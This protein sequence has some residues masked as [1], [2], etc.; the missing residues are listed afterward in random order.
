MPTEAFK[1]IGQVKFVLLGAAIVMLTIYCFMMTYCTHFFGIWSGTGTYPAGVLLLQ[2]VIPYK[3]YFCPIPFLTIIK[4]AL[5]IQIFGD[6]YIVMR[7]AGVG[8]RVLVALFTY[9]WLSRLFKNE[10]AC[11]STIVC[12]VVGSGFETDMVDSPNFDAILCAIATGYL[13]SF[14]LEK[15]DAPLKSFC[16]LSFVAG[17]LAA[18]TFLCKQTIGLGI[19]F[20]LPVALLLCLARLKQFS[21]VKYFLPFFTIG[22]VV[23]MGCAVLW[24]TSVGA[25][26]PFL[27]ENFV[28][29]PSAKGNLLINQ[30][31][32]MSLWWW[33]VL[34]AL[35][36]AILVFTIVRNA[37]VKTTKS[38]ATLSGLFLVLILALS[39]VAGGT[40]IGYQN[41]DRI[42]F[43]LPKVMQ[44]VLIYSSWFAVTLILAYLSL[45]KHWSVERQS[46]HFIFLVVAFAIAS[47]LS[48]SAAAFEPMVVPGLAYLTAALLDSGGKIRTALIYSSAALAITLTTLGKTLIP[49]GLYG[50]CDSPIRLANRESKLPR[51][52]GFVLPQDTVQFIDSTVEI[53]NQNSKPDDYIF[54]YPDVGMF[55]ALT[56]RRCPTHSFIHNIDITPDAMGK[57]EAKLLLEKRP[58]VLIYC[59]MPEKDLIFL[60]KWWR[61]GKQ[62]GLRSIHEACAALSKEYQLVRSFDF[63]GLKCS[64]FVRPN[65][66]K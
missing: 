26:A 55:Y 1:S 41:V 52:K 59:P 40:F 45:K 19:T 27:F 29:A 15:I 28:V 64:V 8:V 60:E 4:S 42:F 58:S 32:N 36:V 34:T 35:I 9:L 53:I 63:S 20:F 39:A 51:L 11:L 50:V 2:G 49:F 12:I 10:T 37:S 17:V 24:L 47:M 43:A 65:S 61:Q 5:L 25:L 22:W 56:D 7:M 44:I 46:Q 62:S 31:N 18:L 21:R 66:G 48:L 6:Q 14:L 38:K 30:F 33:A 23:V 3:D 13:T 57:S 54:V 16:I